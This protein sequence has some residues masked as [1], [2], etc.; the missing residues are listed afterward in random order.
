MRTYDYT[1]KRLHNDLKKNGRYAEP[2]E[3]VH[4]KYFKTRMCAF[5]TISQSVC[6]THFK[7]GYK[8]IVRANNM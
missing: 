1:I 2:I 8:I 5:L 3:C 4:P 6:A 7:I